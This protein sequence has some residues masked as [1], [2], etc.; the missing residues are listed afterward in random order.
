MD[1]LTT[2]FGREAIRFGVASQEQ[3]WQMKAEMKSNRYTTC[4][5]EVLEIF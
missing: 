2:K 4:L 3:N 1:A 5:D